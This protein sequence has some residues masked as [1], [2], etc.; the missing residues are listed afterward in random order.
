MP[1]Y[2]YSARRLSGERV[3]GEAIAASR[4][5]L[6]SR[7]SQDGLVLSSAKSLASGFSFGSV[8]H[9]RVSSKV[10]LTFISEFRA[11]MSAGLPLAQTLRRLETRKDSAALGAAVA[12]VRTDVQS[13]HELTAAMAKHPD[14]FDPL[15]R[16]TIEAGMSSGALTDA[17]DQLLR[18]LRIKADLQR[19]VGRAMTYPL[20]MLVLLVVVLAVL[21]LFVL[22]QFADLYADFGAELP[23]LTKVLLS[24]VDWAPV[25]VPIAIL[26]GF[27][28]L[29]TGRALLRIPAVRQGF[30]R[31]RLSLPF[32]GPLRRDLMLV[33][34]SFILALMLNAGATLQRAV[35]V[36]TDAIDDTDQA[37]RLTRL[38][39]FI[40]QGGSLGHGLPSVALY[41]PLSEA[42]L[43][44]GEEAGDQGQM[45]LEVA[46]LHEND[47]NDRLARVVSL[48][49]PAMMLFVGLVLGTVIIAVYLPIFGLSAVVQ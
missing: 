6:A 15:T 4:D 32:V 34:I 49:E 40:Q 41:P 47:L 44:A 39:Q 22:P 3:A 27:A 42:M 48:I 13:G 10:M 43:T 7:L 20:F 5:E 24:F 1:L 35:K 9:F 45:F 21:M 33:Q 25:I 38:G 8:S 28:V 29:F 36:A 17:L 14:V 19:K 31:L 26:L 37:A 23:F 12:A 46:Q 16:A 2:R 18:L 30:D 11:L